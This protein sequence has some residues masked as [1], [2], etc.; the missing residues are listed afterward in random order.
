MVLRKIMGGA[1]CPVRTRLPPLFHCFQAP[2]HSFDPGPNLFIFL[3]QR[4]PLRGQGILTLLQRAVFI[5]QLVTDLN[6]SIDT[7]LQSF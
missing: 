5:L 4:C 6:E 1:R 2:D 3:Q 7:L